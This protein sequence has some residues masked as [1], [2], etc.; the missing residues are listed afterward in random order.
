[1]HVVGPGEGSRRTASGGKCLGMA[2]RPTERDE[3]WFQRRRWSKAGATLE[4]QSEEVFGLRTQE[5]PIIGR[6]ACLCGR[7]SQPVSVTI[8]I[9][10]SST[11]L[12]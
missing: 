11:G 2:L 9:E 3:N 1:M 8:K 5:E 6:K 4:N 12:P 7:V 10:S